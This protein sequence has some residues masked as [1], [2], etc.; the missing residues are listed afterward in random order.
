MN[1]PGLLKSAYGSHLCFAEQLGFAE[2]TFCETILIKPG[3][4]PT[5]VGVEFV[6]VCGKNLCERC[7]V[8]ILSEMRKA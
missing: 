5:G 6:F 1:Q 4:R 3:D 2:V 7:S 8:A